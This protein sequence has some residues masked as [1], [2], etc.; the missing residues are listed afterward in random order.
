MEK[1]AQRAEDKRRRREIRQSLADFG[2]SRGPRRLPGDA[3]ATDYEQAR[4]Q[5]LRA[6]LESL[7]P[8]FSSFGLYMAT[9]VD[10]MRA[11]DCLEL[12]AISERTAPASP[13]E[14][15]ALIGRELGC[16]P[17]DAFSEFEAA[18]FDSRPLSQTHRA[19]LHD[20]QAVEVKVARPELKRRLLAETE[21]LTLLSGAFALGESEES[22]IED[23]ASDFRRALLQDFTHEADALINLSH[24]AEGVEMLRTPAVYRD[25]CSPNVLTVE[26]L[27]GSSLSRMIPPPDDAETGEAV[28]GA[29][30]GGYDL[31][32][33]LCLVW[34][35]Q[36]LLGRLFP[37]ELRD[38][39]VVVISGKTIAYSGGSFASLS[40]AAK[41][42][43][44]GYLTAAARGD[45]DRACTHLLAELEKGKARVSEEQLRHRLRQIVP[46]RDGGW[47][48][49][50]GNDSLAEHLFLHWRIAGELG[51]RP[52]S[53]LRAFYRGLF[54]TAATARRL[55][56]ER[57]ALLEALGDVRVMAGMAR[58][59]ERLSPQELG[60]NSQRYAALFLEMPQSL[61]EALTLASGGEGRLKI[62]VSPDHGVRRRNNTPSVMISLLVAAAAVALLAHHVSASGMAGAWAERIGAIIFLLFGV[63]L[64]WASRGDKDERQI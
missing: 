62:R 46:F 18:P 16:P 48:A 10:L 45:S 36:S 57:D 58:L 50:G 59:R 49:R 60:E 39:Q 61:D 3:G 44:W 4:V 14:V 13:A 40:V 38:E 28:P 22:V 41:E 11:Q 1:K 24:D 34:L 47:S 51:F 33:T 64:L 30:D 29:S 8:P 20:G 53:H 21:L 31:A 55:A 56:G 25:L 52:P 43:L 54:S 63:L 19:R 2:L 17:R 12:T 7:G 6:A 23:A 27:E 32:H 37:V 9:R 35:R 26:R 42:N 15:E 5:R